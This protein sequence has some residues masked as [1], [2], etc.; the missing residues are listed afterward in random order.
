MYSKV[1]HSAFVLIRSS[2]N[3]VQ[4]IENCMKLPALDAFEKGSLTPSGKVHE[5]SLCEFEVRKERRASIELSLKKIHTHCRQV[6]KVSPKMWRGFEKY[7][8]ILLHE[9]YWYEFIIE[10]DIMTQMKSLDMEIVIQNR[11]DSA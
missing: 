2:H 6:A 9:C 11:S 5:F 3:T 10:S 7:A 1:R 4:E 8:Y